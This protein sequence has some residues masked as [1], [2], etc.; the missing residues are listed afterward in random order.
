MFC[1]LLLARVDVCVGC[2]NTKK[3]VEKKKKS[4]IRARD[5]R[6]KIVNVNSGKG[7][8][9]TRHALRIPVFLNAFLFHKY[10]NK[11]DVGSKGKGKLRV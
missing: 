11:N 2:R 7:F 10:Q 5:S 9:I 1:W 3:E 8:T 4:R 6:Y